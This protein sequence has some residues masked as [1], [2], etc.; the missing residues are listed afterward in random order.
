[1]I[2]LTPVVTAEEIKQ[3]HKFWFELFPSGEMTREGFKKFSSVAMPEA[4]KD[5]DIDYLFR[6]MDQNNSGTVTFKEFLF[7]QSVTA[8]STKPVEP[9]DLIG[10]AFLMYDI[11]QDGYITREEM[12]ECLTNMFKARNLDVTNTNTIRTIES[13]V[14]T[15]IKLAD[16][17]GDDKLTQAEIIESC[18]KDPTLL[19]MF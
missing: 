19:V 5:T 14:D 11:D 17:D 18:K 13:R 10:I 4:P 6:A 15:L 12:K 16:K 7:F 9:E 3:Y 1:M 8:P 2:I